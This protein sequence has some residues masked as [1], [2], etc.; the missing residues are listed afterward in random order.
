MN[1]NAEWYLDHSADT[2]DILH[3]YFL[4]RQSAGRFLTA[5]RRIIR[6]HNGN[7]LNVTVRDVETDSDTFL[8]YATQPMIAFVMFFS[9]PRTVSGDAQMQE[10]TRE[11][12]DAALQAEGRY[13]LPYRLHATPAQFRRAYPQADEYFRLKRQYDP[14]EVFQ[15]QFY[16]KYGK[17]IAT[18]K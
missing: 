8:R 18:T 11:L 3:E 10:M 14:Q 7:L 13:Y 1:D 17:E 4:R 15:N 2:T 5:A 12:I 6:K 16:L 9:Q